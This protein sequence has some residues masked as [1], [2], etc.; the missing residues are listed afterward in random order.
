MS[1]GIASGILKYLKMV[2]ADPYY[3]IRVKAN[4]SAQIATLQS[5]NSGS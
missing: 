5:E 3:G 4:K 1:A 2:D